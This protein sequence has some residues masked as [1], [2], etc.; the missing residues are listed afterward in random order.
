MA[1]VGSAARRRGDHPWGPVLALAASLALANGELQS[2]AQAIDGIQNTFGVPDTLIGLL[3][4]AMAVFIAVGSVPVGILA[5]RVRRTRLLAAVIAV[6]TASMSLHGLAGSFVAL[7]AARTL[8]GTVETTGPAAVSLLADLYPV[9]DRAR[10]MSVYQG[11]ALVGAMVGLLGGGLAVDLGGWRW[12]FW[13]WVPLGVLVV[14]VMLRLSEPRRG[15]Q[16]TRLVA[17]VTMTASTGTGAPYDRLPAP[18]RVPAADYGSCGLREALRELAHIPTMWLGFAGLTVSYLLLNGL[19]FWGI[20]YFKRVHGL[21]ATAAGAMAAV[22]GAGA[23]VGIIGGGF[24]A[25]RYLR[26]GHLNARV[27]VA[28]AGSVGAAVVL[29]PAFASTSL[30][31]TAPLLLAGGVLL[32][33]PIAPAE[34]FVVDVVVPELRGRAFTVRTWVRTTA[35]VSP[36]L[37]GA[38][39]DLLGLRLAL[40]ALCPAYALGGAVMLLARRFYP[41]D[42]A[43]VAAA[44]SRGGR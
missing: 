36:V 5:D 17:D 2:L 10:M 42:L 7:L 12:A 40:V 35:A 34:T 28:A 6:W 9:R 20:E 14:V 38:L 39:S 31:L 30:V 26:R 27:Y 13:M 3:P 16:E 4:F 23:I 29:V 24:L 44:A 11:G 19:T 8:V 22:L 18:R 43:F 1:A 21:G 32:T 15:G 33:L 41:T 25:D 37:I